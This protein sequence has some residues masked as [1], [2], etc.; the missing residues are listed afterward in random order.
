MAQS[1]SPQSLYEE[2]GVAALG[3]GISSNAIYG[4]I[5]RLLE[6]FDARG[7]VLDFGAGL[8]NLTG[9]LLESR[10]FRSVMGALPRR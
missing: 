6:K 2:K 9:R 3:G 1:A 4:T 10:R 5:E 7:D 8:G